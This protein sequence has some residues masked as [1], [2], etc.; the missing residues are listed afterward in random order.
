MP[1]GAAA[2][3]DGLLP[4][5]A[6]RGLAERDFGV[7]LHVP[8]CRV[9]CGYCD[10][11]TYTATELGGGA[12]QDATPTPPSQRS[13]SP[14][15]S[16]RPS[17]QPAPRRP[18][19]SAAAPP[20]SCPPPTSHECCTRCARNGG[21]RPTPRSRPRPTRTRSM[22]PH[23]RGSPRLGSPESPSGCNRPCRTCWPRSTAPTIRGDCLTSSAG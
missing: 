10:F 5:S 2:P 19:S 12:S 20:L 11:N 4:S 7:Y 16:W 15:G 18:Y 6:A 14:R 22:P 1:L 23:S 13:V 9:R 8:F 21:S 17:G 3:T